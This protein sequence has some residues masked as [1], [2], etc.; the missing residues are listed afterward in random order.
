MS[1]SKVLQDLPVHATVTALPL[2][3]PNAK[4]VVVVIYEDVIEPED[5]GNVRPI[6]H[7]YGLMK[8]TNW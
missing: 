1:S 4:F 5:N 3:D 6:R 8:T 2:R 7:E